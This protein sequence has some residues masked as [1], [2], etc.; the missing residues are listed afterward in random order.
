MNTMENYSLDY[1]IFGDGK[2]RYLVNLRRARNEKRYLKI[3]R[4]I[5]DEPESPYNNSSIILFEEDFTF[6]IEALSLVLRR[7]SCG[8]GRPA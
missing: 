5:G 2:D 3:T 1:E 4:K 6:F 8:E 7:Y